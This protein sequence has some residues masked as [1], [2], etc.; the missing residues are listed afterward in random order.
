MVSI[1]IISLMLSESAGKL[2]FLSS[3]PG[4]LTALLSFKELTALE[5]PLGDGW[6]AACRPENK[7]QAWPG[8]S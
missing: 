8:S 7:L 1:S 6:K 3:R 2:A 5:N 4:T